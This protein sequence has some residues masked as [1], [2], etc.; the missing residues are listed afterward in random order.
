MEVLIRAMAV[1][2]AAGSRVPGRTSDKTKTL[3]VVLVPCHAGD[4]LHEIRRQIEA[5]VHVLRPDATGDSEW[6]LYCALVT[7]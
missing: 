3:I 6:K 4:G 7:L 5:T 2:S 1:Q